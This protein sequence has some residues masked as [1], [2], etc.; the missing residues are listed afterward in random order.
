MRTRGG[1]IRDGWIN[2]A[3][4]SV[5]KGLR[6]G[7]L[8]YL[9]RGL[10]RG[11]AFEELACFFEVQGVAVHDE[12]IDTSVVGDGVDVLDGVAVFTKSVDDEIDVY[13]VH[14]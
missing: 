8:R 5:A 2:F 11:F 12:L 4:G 1:R 9:R 3:R 14:A 7:L 13:V 10:F 6:N